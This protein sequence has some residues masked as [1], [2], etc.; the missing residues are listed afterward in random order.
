MAYEAEFMEKLINEE[1]KLKICVAYKKAFNLD[2]SAIF[3]K[4]NF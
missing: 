1:A 3:M 2:I 4:R